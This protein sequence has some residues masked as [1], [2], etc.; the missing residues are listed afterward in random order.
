M[1]RSIKKVE[2]KNEAIINNE[3]EELH[4][5]SEQHGKKLRKNEKI[6][7]ETI[8]QMKRKKLSK[9]LE[10]K[11]KIKKLK[12][13][14]KEAVRL[15]SKKVFIAYEINASVEDLLKGHLPF[16][17][18]NAKHK[19]LSP[20]LRE[21]IDEMELLKGKSE[22]KIKDRINE[23]IEEKNQSIHKMEN[24]KSRIKEVKKS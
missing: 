14:Y 23:L 18:E 6:L 4:L 15:R 7:D 3:I 5:K 24:I 2:G 21:T 22:R 8:L 19:K 12:E 10:T 17:L 11:K 9:K 13:E 20:K 16:N 1:A